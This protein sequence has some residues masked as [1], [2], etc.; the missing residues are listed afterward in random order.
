MAELDA[1]LTNLGEIA[2]EATPSPGAVASTEAAPAATPPSV[3]VN[4][5]APALATEP[6]TPSAPS[7][8]LDPAVAV[9]CTPVSETDPCGSDL[10]I[11]G[12]AAYLNFF[13]QVEGVLPASFFDPIEGTP[14]DPTKFDIA[15]QL[16]A[17]KD[18][19]SRS[20]DIRLLVMRARLHILN[21]DIAGFA[22]SL[23]AAAYWLDG[24]WD[25]VHPRPDGDD[26]STRATAVAVLEEPAV[27]LPLQYAPLFDARRFG[28]IS[29]RRLM[30]ANDEIKARPGEEK[31]TTATIMEAL[32]EADSAKLA[33][34][35]GSVATLRAVVERIRNAFAM[36]GAS[37]GFDAL[38]TLIGKI[39]AF[40]DPVAAAEAPPEPIDGE[41][42]AADSEAAVAAKSLG[43]GPKSLGEASAALAA[44]AEYYGRLEPSSPTLPLVRQAHQLI[45]KSFIEVMNILVPTQLDKAA[46]QIGGD[47]VFDLPL[48]RLASL[49]AVAPETAAPE[50]LGGEGGNGAAGYSV[51]SRAQA[52]ALL[53]QVQ[54]FFRAAEPSSPIPM[55][56]E[57]ARALA[58]R[59]FMGVLRDVLPKAALRNP[60]AER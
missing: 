60:G 6:A 43:P 3:A 22:V 58:E 13:A 45:G 32:G 21:R 11:A 25:Q 1:D 42:G 46:F 24:F 18:L 35:R 29:Y 15:G 41:P 33:V 31:L 9:L 8:P 40:I 48:G 38:P 17:V 20:R 47:Q 16:D 53:E 37:V 54:R 7:A 2:G 14:F 26:L 44:I 28:A 34:V 57:R 5:S 36:H 56:C 51:K 59:D 27:T 52:I 4:G 55:L 50:P 23:A 19:V 12:D 30:M 10:D 39:Q 49:S